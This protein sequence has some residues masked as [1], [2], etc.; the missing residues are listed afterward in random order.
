MSAVSDLKERIFSKNKVNSLTP[1]FQIAKEFGCLSDIMGRDYEV[2]DTNNK[3]LYT[4]RQKPLRFDHIDLITK[5]MA[6]MNKKN[7]KG[8]PSPGKKG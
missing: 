5:E 1:Y 6:K 7:T 2:Y 8:M 3:L 4:I